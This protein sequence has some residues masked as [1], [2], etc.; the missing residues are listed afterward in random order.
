MTM[1]LESVLS[2]PGFVWADRARNDIMMGWPPQPNQ[3]VIPR[4]E[5]TMT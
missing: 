2:D 5:V 3:N 4:N 1:C